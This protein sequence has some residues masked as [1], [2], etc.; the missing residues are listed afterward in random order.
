MALLFVNVSV[1]GGC[2]LVYDVSACVVVFVCRSWFALLI[3]TGCGRCALC[4]VIVGVVGI[5]VAVYCC[6]CC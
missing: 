4:V 5:V 2:L 3:V 6:G 1:G